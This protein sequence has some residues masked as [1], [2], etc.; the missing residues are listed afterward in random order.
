MQSHSDPVLAQYRRVGIGELQAA[1]RALDMG[2]HEMSLATVGE[3]LTRINDMASMLR[4]RRTVRVLE[5]LMDIVGEGG[6]PGGED[7]WE[8]SS[9]VEPWLRSLAVVER[10]VNGGLPNPRVVAEIAAAAGFR[11]VCS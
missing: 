4:H 6:F 8:A 2:V 1:R 11:S 9:S 10:L 7:S 3:C 5:H